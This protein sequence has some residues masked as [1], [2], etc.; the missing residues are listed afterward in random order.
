MDREAERWPLRGK[1]FETEL[2]NMH[3]WLKNRL[4][5]MSY[6]IPAIPE[7][8]D[9]PIA[10][11][12]LCGTIKTNV[13]MQW[14]R[15]YDQSSKVKVSKNHVLS[16]MGLS[17]LVEA[18]VTIVPLFTDG[19]EGPNGT[20]GVFGGWFD[21]DGNPGAYANG[22]V[23]IEVFDDLW[24]WNCG[25]YQWQ[26]WDSEHT[27]TMQYQYPSNGTVLKV[28]VEVTFKIENNGW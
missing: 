24:N 14:D 28:N 1:D 8:D 12:K 17:E 9:T 11:D 25:L 3:S 22:H 4:I 18:N 20:N 7:P 23:Y 5:H 26:C 27:V 21:G 6:L 10:G 13:T 2:E 19:S 15:G 16:L